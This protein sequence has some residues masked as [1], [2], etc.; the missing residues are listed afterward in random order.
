M[1]LRYGYAHT[2]EDAFKKRDLFR[3]IP[4]K[5]SKR[6]NQFID[7]FE[8]RYGSLECAGITQ[9]KIDNFEGFLDQR[10]VCEPLIEWVIDKCNE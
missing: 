2:K 4:R 9:N 3:T 5:Y 6:A 7:Q 1:G 8:Q 10:E